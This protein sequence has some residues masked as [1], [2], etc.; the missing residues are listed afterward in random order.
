MLIWRATRP[1]GGREPFERQGIAGS[2]P[3][4]GLDHAV[5]TAAYGLLAP[6]TLPWYDLVAWGLLP[7]VVPSVLDGL[8]PARLTLIAAA[9]VPGG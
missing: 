8:L 3:T 4:G 6:Y 2:G 5:L 7:L 1:L 9:Y